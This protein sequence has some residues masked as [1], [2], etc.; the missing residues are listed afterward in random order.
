MLRVLL[1]LALLASVTFSWAQETQKTD[2]TLDVQ[3]QFVELPV[4][5][6]DKEGYPFRG[7]NKEHFKVYE[8]KVMQDISLFKQ[9][10]TPLTVGLVLDSS[11]SMVSKKNRLSAAALTFVQESNPE[12]ETFIMGFSDRPK[13][14][15]DFTSDLE[16]LRRSLDRIVARGNTA[17]YDGVQ[18]AAQHLENGFHEKKVLLVVSDG[19]D[20]RSNYKLDELL[21]E[22]RE[23][24]VIVYTVGLMSSDIGFAGFGPLKGKARKGLEELAK[25][26]GGRAF[27]PKSVDDVDEV[28]RRIA[29]ELR[30]HYTIGYRPSNERLDGKYRKVKVQLD[31]PKGTPKLSV[32]TKQGYY[33][34]SVKRTAK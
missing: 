29:R 8:D 15:Q 30:N 32:R 18:L 22:I 14:E 28:C 21:E 4:T 31:A 26:T 19:E 1:T 24:K 16:K 17:L 2:Y 12:D 13:L 3:V 7:L 33:A 9:E 34:P 27:F 25:V 10:D 20:N 23:S 6:L 5:V 11:S